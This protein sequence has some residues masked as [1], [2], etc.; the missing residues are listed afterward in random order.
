[1]RKYHIQD[2]EDYHKF[3]SFSFSSALEGCSL[4]DDAEEGWR[5]GPAGEQ[6]VREE[7]HLTCDE[8]EDPDA[9]S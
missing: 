4:G 2:R 1:M 3:V 9:V 7:A 6:G 5:S 8:R